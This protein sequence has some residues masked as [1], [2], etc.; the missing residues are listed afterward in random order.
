VSSTDHRGSDEN[1]ATSDGGN[2][3]RRRGFGDGSFDWR[4]MLDGPRLWRRGDV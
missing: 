3:G 4:S 2:H 1:G